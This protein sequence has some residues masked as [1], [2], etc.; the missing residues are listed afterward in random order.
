MLIIKS[1]HMQ[2][3]LSKSQATVKK[4]SKQ[5]EK[6][7]DDMDKLRKKSEQLEATVKKLEFEL[8]TAHMAYTNRG[9]DKDVV[10]GELHKAQQEND[11]LVQQTQQ[12][13]RQVEQLSSKLAAKEAELSS[14]RQN[15]AA[16][17]DRSMSPAATFDDEGPSTPTFSRGAKRPRLDDATSSFQNFTADS[18]KQLL[19][20]LID[21]RLAASGR[22]PAPPH[23]QAV[24]YGQQ[25]A[26]ASP[27]HAVVRNAP[28]DFFAAHVTSAMHPGMAQAYGGYQRPMEPPGLWYTAP[29]PVQT[30][31]SPT[32]V[33]A[34]EPAQ[35][36]R[37]HAQPSSHLSWQG[38]AFQPVHQQYQASSFQPASQATSYMAQQPMVTHMPPHSS[39]MLPM[40]PSQNAPAQSAPA[41]AAG[42]VQAQAQAQAAA[43]AKAAQ[44][45]AA[46]AQAVQ[47]QAAQARA[48][49]AQ[50]AEAQAAEAQAAEARAAQVQAA[51]A[52]AA[53]AQ[54]AQA[55]AAQAQT[56]A[57]Q[58]MQETSYQAASFQ[59]LPPQSTV[60]KPPTALHG[61]PVPAPVPPTA[62]YPGS[63][64]RV[65]ALPM[66]NDELMALFLQR[67]GTNKPSE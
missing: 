21:E 59:P 37:V 41:Q 62:P 51:Q 58:V 11:K 64:S 44:A 14:L 65:P 20:Q 46:L 26:P 61:P 5:A 3:E 16:A 52:R 31:D 55:R 7:V 10:K 57:A 39:S 42:Q 17:G 36:Q 45:Q 12:L 66:T 40:L 19:S 43:R 18:M 22:T 38:P 8:E 30:P 23:P 27:Q 28:P 2:E 49:E 35:Y 34:A 48:A 47:D 56:H 25:P 53:Q 60:P 15:F 32:A 24:T 33:R 1:V 54:A 63:V 50:A 13:K 29:M 4:L 9:H 67:F 6:H